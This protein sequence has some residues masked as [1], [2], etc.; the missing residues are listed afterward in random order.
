MGVPGFSLIIKIEEVYSIQ[1][2]VLDF[3]EDFPEGVYM[4]WFFY[5]LGYSVF[6]AKICHLSISRLLEKQLKQNLSALVQ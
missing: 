1:V 2:L 5:G 6:Y 3:P 4:T